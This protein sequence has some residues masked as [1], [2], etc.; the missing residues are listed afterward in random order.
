[1]VFAPLL[2]YANVLETVGLLIPRELNA[3]HLVTNHA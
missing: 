1:M 2:M 3:L